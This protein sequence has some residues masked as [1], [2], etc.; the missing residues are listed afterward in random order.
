MGIGLK[1]E[2]PCRSGLASQQQLKMGAATLE[3]ADGPFFGRLNSVTTG[4]FQESDFIDRFPAMNLMR[5]RSP[6]DPQAT[7]EAFH[8]MSATM[9]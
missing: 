9:Q 1:R 3:K 8:K 6:G 7:F 4:G 5:T 2:M